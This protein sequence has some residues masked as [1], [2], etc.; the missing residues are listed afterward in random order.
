[1]DVRRVLERD[2]IFALI[3][4]ETE[5]LHRARRIGEEPLLVRRIGPRA[6][7]DA[8][9]VARTDLRLECVDDP[10]ERGAIDEPLV[11]QQRFQRFDPQRQ[12]GGNDLMTGILVEVRGSIAGSTGND[13]GGACRRALQKAASSDGVSEF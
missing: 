7:D 1:V 13:P 6:R 3:S 9:P 11:D 5:L 12:I 2:D 10:I 8:R 4:L